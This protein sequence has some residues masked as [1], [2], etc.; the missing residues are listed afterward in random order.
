MWRAKT[1]DKLQ[2]QLL[3]AERAKHDLTPLVIHS[4]YL[5]NLA[6]PP[7]AVRENSIHA[8]RGE[9]ERGLI[10]GAEYL[11]VHPGNYR[12]LTREQGMLNVAEAMALAWRAVDD[13]VKTK[14]SLSVL[15]ESTAGAGTQLGGDLSELAIIQQL[16]T[17][18]LDIPIGFCLDTCHCHVYGFDLA[19]QAGFD[20]LLTT[21]RE[22]LGLEHIPVIHSNDTKARCGSHLGH[23]FPDGPAP[24]GERFC[25]NSTAM[26][27]EPEGTAPAATTKMEK[28][29]F[30]AGC[31]WGV[32]DKFDHTKGVVKTTAGY[33]GGS[34]P[35]PTYEDV[36]SHDTG[37]AEAVEVEFDPS[38]VSYD[39][40]LSM[41]WKMHNPAQRGGQ[42]PDIGDNYRSAIFYETPEQKAA[43]EASKEKM[44]TEGGYKGGI[45][46]EI[47]K[48]STFYPA[49][50]YHQHYHSR[51][52]G[53]LGK[54]GSLF[55]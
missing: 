19:T 9:L 14:P 8:F 50:T 3:A 42:G 43:A 10:I 46:T 49:E 1:P 7:S 30:A 55:Q 16:A 11:V 51:K 33:T 41:F 45:A 27:F 44:N 17:K 53:V 38:V 48:A 20:T 22:T 37:H 24:T 4:N 5:I 21:A 15:L 26:N 18:Y 28:A 23:V 29:I 31:F 12:G 52:P 36:C 13:A 32:Q 6:A 40:L 54:L 25:M 2:V 39:D 47:T 35:N 34:T